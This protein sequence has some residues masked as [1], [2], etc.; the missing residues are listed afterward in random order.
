VAGALSQL[1]FVAIAYAVLG[2]LLVGCAAML[3]RLTWPA[4][5]GPSLSH[6]LGSPT[7]RA[8]AVYVSLGVGFWVLA[9]M[10]LSY[11]SLS[12][13][14]RAVTLGASAL[15]ALW[16]IV[17]AVE[18][19]LTRSETLGWIVPAWGLA[20]VY[21]LCWYSLWYHRRASNNRWRGP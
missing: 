15:V 2:A 14:L 19:I 1:R 18:T 16:C 9:W 5:A 10:S 21:S 4:W 6:E 8:V 7:A 17:D 3:V 11:L 20:L 12:P 13:A